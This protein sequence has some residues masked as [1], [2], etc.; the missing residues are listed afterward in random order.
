MAKVLKTGDKV[1]WQT[2]S[3]ETTGTVE[4]IL[5][6]PTAIKGHRVA[7]SGDNPEYLVKSGKSGK[8]AAHK[9]DALKK[10]AKP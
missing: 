2:P 10:I 6:E 5:T 9:P 7:A 8:T 1:K 4:R 3:G